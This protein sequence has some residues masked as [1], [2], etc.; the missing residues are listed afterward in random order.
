MPQKIHP[1]E[2]EPRDK[3]SPSDLKNLTDT[4][5]GDIGE[6]DIERQ[7]WL[8]RQQHYYLRRYVRVDRGTSYPYPGAPDIVPPMMDMAIDRQA[9]ELQRILFPPKPVTFK[10]HR[11]D[12]FEAVTN[13]ELFMN[14]LILYGMRDF[15]DQ[16]G[17]GINSCLQYGHG[18]F[19]TFW[20]YRARKVR[21]VIRRA[22]VL[23]RYQGEI[24]EMRQILLE[25][26]MLSSG[27]GAALIE[28]PGRISREV[29][30]EII[31]QLRP[32]IM[33]DL[34]LEDEIPEDRETLTRILTE[35][36]AGAEQVVY[37]TTEVEYN[38][39][40]TVAVPT[41][42]FIVPV[43][44]N[45]ISLATRK[46]H[47]LWLTEPSFLQRAANN[48]W[49]RSAVDRIL[50][51]RNSKRQSGQSDAHSMSRLLDLE[52][53]SREGVLTVDTED[54][55][56]VWETH[57]FMRAGKARQPTRVWATIHPGSKELLK[58]YRRE[59]Y[60]HGGD[61]FDKIDYEANE[62]RYYSSRGIPEKIDDLDAEITFAHRMRLVKKEMMIPSFTRRLGS[63]L[64]PDK[65]HWIPG[66][67]YDVI[68]HDDLQPI[69]VPDQTA[70]EEREEQFL[71]ALIERYIGGSVDILAAQGQIHEART[72]REIA[73]IERGGASTLDM[74]ART[75]QRGMRRVYDKIWDCWNQWGDLGV[76]AEGVYAQVAGRPFVRSS[77]TEIRNNYS[78][79]PIGT[80]LNL[81][82]ALESQ[83]A[84]A[85]FQVLSELVTANE[86]N[87]VIDGTHQIDR[88]EAL[89]RW[90]ERDNVTDA[91]ALIRRLSPEEQQQIQQAAQA[92]QEA[93]RR[94]ETIAL[95]AAQDES[96]SRE[97]TEAEG[98][99]ERAAAALAADAAEAD[100][101]AAGAGAAG[102]GTGEA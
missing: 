39:P 69:Q 56:E 67:V 60:E 86:N 32:L 73:A 2:Q 87:P 40:R 53:D 11:S 78:L 79:I 21:R 19:K 14:W 63:I 70:V 1:V 8:E 26:Q 46:T 74:R 34:G 38:G 84:F 29:F 61:A 36:K 99:V 25:D 102:N 50:D 15:E 18:I 97:L 13:H 28:N 77:P 75:I 57:F 88:G 85:R 65:M 62:P 66:G 98:S 55:V 51:N 68:N 100:A 52:R 45:E 16:V 59:P 83:R 12:N 6:D 48:G 31:D 41:Q 9:S 58:S 101:A 33:R 64:D 54:L 95:G 30:S 49:D 71:A 92:A 7:Q 72:A 93:Q 43:G 89:I 80:P 94:G 44:T 91:R 76:E 22:E 90:L 23:I 47:R 4:L 10:T 37:E 35:F 17:Y 82:P 96:V 20:D 81:D 42:D 24:Q 5:V 3:F 27:G